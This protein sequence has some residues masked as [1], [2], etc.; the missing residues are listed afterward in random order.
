M[1]K[2]KAPKLVIIAVVTVATLLVWII[3]RFT[4]S[5]VEKKTSDVPKEILSP[6][7]PNIDT[8]T[9]SELNGRLYYSEAQITEGEVIPSTGPTPTASPSA[10]PQVSTES[11]IPGGEQ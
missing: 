2:I 11:G 4:I 1:Q 8:K 5:I 7:D 9:L 10:E 6:I 3:Y